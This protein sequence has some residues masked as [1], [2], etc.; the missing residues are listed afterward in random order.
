MLTR[1]EF[2]ALPDEDRVEH[3]EGQPVSSSTY[4][5]WRCRCEGCREAWA[6]YVVERKRMRGNEMA[7]GVEA[8]L[9]SGH[10]KGRPF[11][12]NTYTNWGCRCK[13]C[14]A[15]HA[16]QARRRRERRSA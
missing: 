14:T 15:D 10:P 12:E 7:T 8:T 4:T 9:K 11:N 1:K 3:P 2:R 6:A 16:E 5:N 13:L